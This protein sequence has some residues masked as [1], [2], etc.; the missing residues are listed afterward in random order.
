MAEAEKAIIDRLGANA[1]VSALVSSRVYFTEAPQTPAIPYAVIYRIDSPRVH[2][3]TGP[4]GLAAAR[5]QVDCYAK[6][7]KE[8]REVGAAVRVSLDGFRGLQSGV[9]VQGVLLL[10]EMDGY[11]ESSEL[12]RVTQDYRVWYRE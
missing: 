7:A 1:T 2:S 11:S 3:M 6:T 4:S 8:A 10:D 5:I 12:K 9:N